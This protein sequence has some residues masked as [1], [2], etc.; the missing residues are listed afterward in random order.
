MSNSTAKQKTQASK[1]AEGPRGEKVDIIPQ[2]RS[3]LR[4][5]RIDDY[6]QQSL[7]DADHFRANLGATSADL[8]WLSCE[9]ARVIREE[10]VSAGRNSESLRQL[11]PHIE[12]HLKLVRQLDRLAN[13][14]RQ[15]VA[16]Q[17]A[18]PPVR[19]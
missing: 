15:L 14:D 13:L 16:G 2:D 19:S 3:K 18:I 8:M 17:G 10:F 7:Q 9:S 12:L 4:E 11:A 1:E 6:M 5:G